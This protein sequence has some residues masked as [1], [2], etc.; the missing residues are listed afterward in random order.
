MN[1]AC[2]R[3]KTCMGYLDLIQWPATLVTILASWLV[4]SILA[5]RRGAGFRIFLLSNVMWTVWGWS[6]GARA[7]SCCL[8]AR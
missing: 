1:T 2:I 7:N 4:A 8:N 5:C 3:K 6:T